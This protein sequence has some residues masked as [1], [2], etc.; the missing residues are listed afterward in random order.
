MFFNQSAHGACTF[1]CY[2][3]ILV[4]CLL[5]VNLSWQR[6]ISC[7]F[8]NMTLFRHARSLKVVL[9]T[10]SGLMRTPTVGPKSTKILLSTLFLKNTFT[11]VPNEW[12]MMKHMSHTVS[13]PNWNTRKSK[14]RMRS[15]ANATEMWCHVPNESTPLVEETFTALCCM[16]KHL[17]QGRKPALSE[18]SRVICN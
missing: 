16:N 13:S 1:L 7:Y 15:I 3:T 6:C 17:V 8:R 2:L 18:S 9:P 10:V 4:A 11:M 12:M 5:F 14:N